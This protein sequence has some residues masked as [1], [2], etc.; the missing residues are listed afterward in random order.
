MQIMKLPNI[1]TKMPCLCVTL[2][3]ASSTVVTTLNNFDRSHRNL[4][5]FTVHSY[6]KYNLFAFCRLGTVY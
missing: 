4:K 2:Y 5:Y 3:V 6:L 1:Q